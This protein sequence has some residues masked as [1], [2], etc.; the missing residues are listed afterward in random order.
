[1]YKTNSKSILLLCFFTY[2]TVYVLRVNF[3]SAMPLLQSQANASSAFFYH[4]CGRPAG[5]RLFSGF[6]VAVSF[7]YFRAD[8]NGSGK[9]GDCFL[10]QSRIDS[11]SLGGQRLLSVYFLGFF[12]QASFV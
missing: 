11:C 5:K 9:R 1:M 6:Y 8:W 2:L 7:Y 10:Q 4:L 3:S 12:D